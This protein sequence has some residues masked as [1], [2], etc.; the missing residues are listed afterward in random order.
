MTTPDGSVSTVLD[1]GGLPAGTWASATSNL[2]GMPSQCGNLSNLSAKPDEDMLIAGIALLGLWAS[3]DGGV[4]W[5]ALGTGSDASAP[6]T[7]R[8]SS[9]VYDPVNLQ[10]FWE[11]GIYN[12][13]GVYETTD[14]GATFVLMGDSFHN[15]LVSIDF[16]DP[17]RRTLLAGGHEQS[18]TLY[19]STDSGMTWPNIGASLPPSTNCVY[20]LIMNTTTYLVGCG[21][22]GGGVS[23]IYQST[24]SGTTWTM[25]STAGGSF[26]P[27]LASDQSIYWSTP[28]N[29]GI[30]R[31][32]DGGKTWTA[33]MGAGM[34]NSVHPIELPDGRIATIGT[35]NGSL[36]VLVSA[37]HAATWREVTPVLPYSDP[38][39]LVYS[40]QRQAFYVWHFTC[41]NDAVPVPPD[42][43]VTF[44]FALQSS[45][46][47]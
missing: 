5:Q 29:G 12:G 45:S 17:Q 42:A 37:D 15:D 3:R 21:G 9:I 32:T 25:M 43:I 6:I 39:G 40:A 36:G 7:N 30:T 33:P 34:L 38:V 47:Q 46:E 11:S 20:P 26:A 27:L 1:S 44:P 13:G 19:R 24:D 41:G 14:D 18:Q 8:T 31:S 4:T 10:T 22:Y 2:A 28:N 23:G 16:T 35:V